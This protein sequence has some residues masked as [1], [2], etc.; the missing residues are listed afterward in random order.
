ML[1]ATETKNMRKHI[2]A[3]ATGKNTFATV[4]LTAQPNV[5][6]L[7]FCVQVLYDEV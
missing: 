5:Y 1:Y 2:E 4:Y 3:L 6:V 7:P